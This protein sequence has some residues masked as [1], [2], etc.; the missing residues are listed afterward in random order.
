INDP[1]PSHGEITISAGAQIYSE[2]TIAFVT[3]G[4][5]S[6]DPDSHYGTRNLE[7]SIG[8]INIGTPQSMAG[9]VVPPGLLLTQDL[10]DTLFAGDTSVGAPAL[11]TLTLSASQSV[12]FFGSID[13]SVIDPA[14]GKADLDL[15]L[16]TPAIYGYGASTDTATLSVGRLFWGGLGTASTV[17]N[18]VQ[19]VSLPPAP[20]TTG[21]PGTGTGTIN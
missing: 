1:L 6:I 2:G 8:A 17:P 13:L 12:N 7:L 3:G 11:Q 14:T 5:V 9:A 20:V 16:D 19:P 15:V 21:G 4:A 10:L 18:I